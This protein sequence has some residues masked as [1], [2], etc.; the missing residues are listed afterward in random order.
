LEEISED[1]YNELVASTRLITSIDEANIGLED[2][3]ASG[4]CPVR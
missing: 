1:Q 2:D 4:A 3:C